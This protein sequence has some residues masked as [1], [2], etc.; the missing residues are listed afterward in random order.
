MFVD[1]NRLNDRH[2][3]RQFWLCQPITSIPNNSISVNPITENVNNLNSLENEVKITRA[4]EKEKIHF[5]SSY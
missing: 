3:D 1:L 5:T 4:T 2:T